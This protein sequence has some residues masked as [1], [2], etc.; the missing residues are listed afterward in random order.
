[1]TSFRTKKILENLTL[2]ERLASLRKAKAI[3][4]ATLA[5]KTGISQKYLLALEEGRY[6]KLPSRL[7]AKNY[8]KSYLASLAVD[9]PEDYLKLF[10]SEQSI[11][12]KT[13]SYSDSPKNASSFNW[14]KILKQIE[15]TPQKIKLALIGLTILVCFSYL[16][17]ETK[18]FFSPP[19][20]V[21]EMPENNL[22]T[23][24]QLIEVK[25]RTEKEANLAINGQ[26]I[27]VASDGSFSDKIFLQDGLNIIKISA[28][29][30]YSKDNTIFRKVL[31]IGS[32]E[33]K[34][35]VSTK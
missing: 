13:N 3:N 5:K 24:K 26:E 2:G 16:G 33:K 12:Q 18:K 15:I 20:L 21:I 9:R 30:R 31:V 35:E 32:D 34:Q 22:I 25:G 10:E 1:M 14:Q 6:Q 17:W 23:N 29:K 8:L 28:K 4:L 27:F 19:R 11:Y 7:Y